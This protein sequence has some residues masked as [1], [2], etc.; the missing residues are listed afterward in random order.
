[1]QHN[2][3]TVIPKIG[4]ELMIP[5]LF[6]ILRD[7]VRSYKIFREQNMPD[8]DKP[9]AT[10]I[11]TTAEKLYIFI[12]ITAEIIIFIWK[13]DIKAIKHFISFCLKQIIEDKTL[14]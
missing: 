12:F 1:M 11:I 2:K 9:W 4:I 8:E 14:P 10:I 5:L 3:K 13:I 7:F 6:K